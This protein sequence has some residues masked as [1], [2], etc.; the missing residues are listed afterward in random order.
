MSEK[1][2]NFVPEIKKEVKTFSRNEKGDHAG[3]KA[4]EK[5]GRRQRIKEVTAKHERDGGKR[6][7]CRR[8]NKNS[9]NSPLGDRKMG[10][11]EGFTA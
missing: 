9:S 8:Q 10:R 6:M 11:K 4:V 2:R 5:T 1:S 7:D 3:C